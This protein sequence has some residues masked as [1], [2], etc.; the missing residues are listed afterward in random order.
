[1]KRLFVEPYCVTERD[2]R[3][4]QYQTFPL[5][6]SWPAARTTCRDAGMV[7]PH[8]YGETETEHLKDFL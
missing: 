8:A 1:M 3:L 6:L 5:H 2:V 7:M 4:L